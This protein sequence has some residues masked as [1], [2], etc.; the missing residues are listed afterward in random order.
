V[1]AR[2]QC[3][4][5]YV[6]GVD[7][8][9]ALDGRLRVATP[10][11]PDRPGHTEQGARVV[12]VLLEHGQVL[13]LRLRAVVLLEEE[14]PDP[15]AGLLPVG[16]ARQGLVEG[17]QRV[18]EHVGLRP[19]QIPDRAP[20]GD[21]VAGAHLS[22][23]TV[24]DVDEAVEALHRLPDPTPVEQQLG[25]VDLGG[26]RPGSSAAPRRLE[27]R[28]GLVEP[29]H[30]EQRLARGV[31]DGGR[32]RGRPPD[33]DRLGVG[34]RRYQ[35]LH[36]AD[37]GLHGS[38]LGADGGAIGV[39]GLFVVSGPLGGQGLTGNLGRDGG[40]EYRGE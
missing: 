37:P 8:E 5:I 3:T 30:P 13:G 18:L 39:D 28:L 38:G 1:L 23:R 29:A 14:V 21:Q 20:D 19:P 27:R 25:Q 10:V 36:E 11:E 35:R 22:I 16:I 2:Q 12:R 31:R 33:L 7:L 32:I 6:V 34:T 9:H 17:P 26:E 4:R 40:S 24:V 15:Y